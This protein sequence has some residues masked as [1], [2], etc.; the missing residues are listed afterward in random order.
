[1]GRAT[2]HTL[3]RQQQRACCCCC[4]CCCSC[5]CCPTTSTGTSSTEAGISPEAEQHELLHWGRRYRRRLL[6]RGPLLPAIGRRRGV[7]GPRRKRSEV[8]RQQRLPHAWRAHCGRGGARTPSGSDRVAQHHQVRLAREAR[9][10]AR[11][12][13]ELRQVLALRLALRLKDVVE[14]G[15]GHALAR[16]IGQHPL[17]GLGAQRDPVRI[18]MHWRRRT[19]LGGQVVPPGLVAL[20]SLCRGRAPL[21]LALP[22]EL[23]LVGGERSQRGDGGRSPRLPVGHG[24]RGQQEERAPTPLGRQRSASFR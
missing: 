9:H 18:L 11:P 17:D 13:H 7:C 1:M 2:A 12:R 4:C 24:A 16:L 21:L 5:C 14:S 10:R 19:G 3:H 20:S 23:P 8:W 6:R 22:L 15:D